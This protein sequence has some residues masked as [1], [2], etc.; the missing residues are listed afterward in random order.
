LA[1]GQTDE[2]GQ[3]TLPLNLEAHTAPMLRVELEGFEADGG[4]GVRTE[5]S[6]LLSRQAYIW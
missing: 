3:A 6:T 2:K 4:R 5:L 1:D